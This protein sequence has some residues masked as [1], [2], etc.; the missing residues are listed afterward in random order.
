MITYGAINCPFLFG[1]IRWMRKHGTPYNQVIV[2]NR[3]V[4]LCEFPFYEIWTIPKRYP[5]EISSG[6]KTYFEFELICREL[7]EAAQ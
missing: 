2:A 6:R 1:W 7:S 3:V 5:T 4:H